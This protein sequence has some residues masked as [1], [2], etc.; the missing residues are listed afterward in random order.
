MAFGRQFEGQ[1]CLHILRLIWNRRAYQSVAL[2][3]VYIVA[4]EAWRLK[5]RHI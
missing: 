1:E 3:A 5:G 2:E 4:S